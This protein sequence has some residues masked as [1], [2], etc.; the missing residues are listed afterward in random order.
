MNE[1]IVRLNKLIEKYKQYILEIQRTCEHDKEFIEWKDDWNGYD[2]PVVTMG[3]D[4][5]RC[6]KCGTLIVEQIRVGH[7]VLLDDKKSKEVKY[8][9]G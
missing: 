9:Y 8:Y 5:Y 1:E 2:Y 7:G 4:Y 3:Y 6:K